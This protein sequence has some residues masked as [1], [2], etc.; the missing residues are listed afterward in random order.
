MGPDA[1]WLTVMSMPGTTERACA[2]TVTV[3]V[4]PS[5][6]HVDPGLSRVP[7]ALDAAKVCAAGTA[8]LTSPGRRRR[9]PHPRLRRCQREVLGVAGDGDLDAAEQQQQHHREQ[10]HP[11]QRRATAVTPVLSPPGADIHGG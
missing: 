3:T 7:S 10:Q 5:H 11:G 9:R 1:L 2:V 8:R 6:G 4:F